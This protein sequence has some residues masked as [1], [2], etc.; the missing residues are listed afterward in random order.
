M[1]KGGSVERTI[2]R[3]GRHALGLTALSL[4][5]YGIGMAAPLAYVPNEGSGTVSVIDTDKDVVIK[6]IKAGTKPRGIA[7]GKEA[8]FLYVSDQPHNAL[9]VIDLSKPQVAESIDLG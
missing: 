7:T 4:L 9:L 6:E 3:I 2:I 8:K 1:R 5:S